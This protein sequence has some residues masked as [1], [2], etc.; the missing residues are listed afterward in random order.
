MEWS[1]NLISP[2]GYPRCPHNRFLHRCEIA[3]FVTLL[4]WAAG[5]QGRA[6]AHAR[7]DNVRTP[8]GW[9]WA[10]ISHGRKAD[11]NAF[12]R[13]P[14]L[15]SRTKDDFRWAKACRRLPSSFLVDVLVH[16]PWRAQ[17]QTAGVN[18]IGAKIVGDINLRYTT[19]NRALILDKCRI[20]SNVD[21]TGARTDS[22]VYIT[23]SR[24]VGIFD[25]AELHSGLSVEFD[26]SQFKQAISLNHAVIAGY[27]SMD[28]ASFDGD[29]D[30]AGLQLGSSLY[31]RST[32][33][34]KATFK[35]VTL[36]GARVTGNVSIVGTTFDGDINADSLIVASFLLLRSEGPNKASF[37]GISLSGAK[38]GG[39]VDMQGATLD[40]ELDAG[41]LQVGSSLYMRSISQYKASFKRVFLREANV[42]GSVDMDG[43][44]IDGNMV[45]DRLQVGGA[46]F[47]RGATVTKPLTLESGHIGTN[48]DMRRATLAGLDL[49]ETSVVG[50][51]VLG[52]TKSGSA[53]WQTKADDSNDLKLY[54]TRVA[55]LMDAK[56]AWPKKPHLHL[57]GFAFAHLGGFEDDTG[58]EMRNR[59]IQWWDEWIRTDPTYSPTPYEQL[60]A[61]LIAAGDPDA[62]DEIRFLGRVRQR[63][64][65]TRWWPWVS[66]GI[67]QYVAGFGIG[68]HK[69]RVL[70]WVIGISVAAAVYL[71]KRVPQAKLHGR[72]WCFGAS[73]NRLLPII[74]INKEFSD[75]FNDPERKRLTSWQSFVFSAIGI[76][77]WVLG[78]ILVAAVSG[79]TQK[80]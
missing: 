27:I 5:T 32:A 61:A 30:A 20:E 17:V 4:V 78:A 18:I 22:V 6:F 29:L 75:F 80:P 35:A 23:G 34:N 44:T 56:D 40:G 79:L 7:Y 47:M 74:E 37:K 42:A 31:L 15:D 68:K 36:T 41:A 1:P 11:L 59:P 14:V 33:K 2:K 50:D 10:Q 51:L 63:Q 52:G 58:L 49:S 54:N 73:L 24:L 19:L 57:D 28:G 9:A 62:A 66:D 39:N 45:A 12:C 53:V 8:E 55:N 25:A 77:G 70:Y 21:L 72:I 76:V 46:L 65:E 3:L 67:L 60:A 38:V 64:A 69:F 26:D 13:T 43:A 16:A 71:W 48:L